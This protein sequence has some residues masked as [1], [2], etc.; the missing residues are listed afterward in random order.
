MGDSSNWWDD[1]DNSVMWQRETSNLF[2]N[3]LLIPFYIIYKIFFYEK[4]TSPHFEYTTN[5]QSSSLEFFKDKGLQNY[6]IE[7]LFEK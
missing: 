5:S 6:I 4:K 1:I 2:V 7:F 3:I